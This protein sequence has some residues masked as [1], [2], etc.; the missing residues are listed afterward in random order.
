MTATSLDIEALRTH[1]TALI[2]SISNPQ[3]LWAVTTLLEPHE[4][5]REVAEADLAFSAADLARLNRALAEADR[6]EGVHAEQVMAA[7]WAKY[8]NG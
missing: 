8:G 6:G 2:A 3:L 5:A 1:V 4:G 7:L